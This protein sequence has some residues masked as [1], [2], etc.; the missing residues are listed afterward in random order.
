[1]KLSEYRNLIKVW[2]ANYLT[3]TDW[4]ENR[5]LLNQSSGFLPPLED[6]KYSLENGL[7]TGY[8]TQKLAVSYRIDKLKFHAI[9]F[10][11]YEGVHSTLSQR[12]LLTF[13]DIHPDMLGIDVLE[14]S[15][16]I[17]TVNANESS[18][19]DWFIQIQ[20]MFRINWVAES[21]VAI[22]KQFIVDR[23]DVGMFLTPLTDDLFNG[24]DDDKKVLDKEF[25]V[26]RVQDG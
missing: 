21:E 23:I 13:S 16:P 14:V 25:S 10:S 8:G 2:L 20:W 1:M 24:L 18:T 17:V 12:L 15:S 7:I 22:V 11:Y 6:V 26:I 4:T 19:D 5:P 9:P 3:V